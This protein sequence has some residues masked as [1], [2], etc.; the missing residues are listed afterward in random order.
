MSAIDE[1]LRHRLIQEGTGVLGRDYAFSHHTI[2]ETLYAHL[3]QRRRQHIHAQVGGGMELVYATQI[4]ALAG[5]LA[6]HF[7]QGRGHDPVLAAK[8]LHYLWLA[9]DQA[10]TLYA[11]QEAV[12]Y[13][14][15][16]LIIAKDGGD[17]EAAAH[18]LFRLGLTHHSVYDF[19]PA[20]QSY[21]YSFTFF[22]LFILFFF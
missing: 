3:S 17:D 18:T 21:N 12:A 5:E 8:A 19:E 16:A 6:Y 1:M 13:Y 9:G 20:G 22:L 15:R 14:Q 10:R 7:E 2:Q 4:E 11:S